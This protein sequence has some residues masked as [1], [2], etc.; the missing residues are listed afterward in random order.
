MEK[1][2]QYYL[3]SAIVI[4]TVIVGFVAISNYSRVSSVKIYD[5]GKELKIEGEKVIDYGMYNDLDTTILLEEFIED[6]A[7][8]RLVD[9]LYFVFGNTNEITLTGYQKLSGEPIIVNVGD[10]DTSMSFDSQVPSSEIFSLLEDKVIVTANDEDYEFNFGIGENF[11]FI[12][13][14]T[15]KGEKH[16]YVDY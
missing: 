10:E 7:Q 15:I 13:I 11:H 12:M 6:Y 5:L 3:L 16:V 14:K 2:G 4:I 8:Y 9:E 1:K